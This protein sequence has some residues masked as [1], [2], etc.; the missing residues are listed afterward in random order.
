[1]RKLLLAAILAT[2]L[3]LVLSMGVGATVVPC[4]H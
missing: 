2:L 3:M 1:M 4:C